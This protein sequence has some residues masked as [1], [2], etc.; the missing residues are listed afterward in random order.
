M[1]RLDAILFAL[2]APH[3]LELRGDTPDRITLPTSSGSSVW[4][5]SFAETN[6]LPER[7]K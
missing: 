4:P 6:F 7:L 5:A 2:F 3:H 1:K